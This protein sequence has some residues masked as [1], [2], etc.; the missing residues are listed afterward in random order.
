MSDAVT[1]SV[2]IWAEIVAVAH[3]LTALAASIHCVLT[4]EEPRATIGWVGLIWLSPIIGTVLYYLL[5]INRI[6][7]KAVHLM[8]TEGARELPATP[9][10]SLVGDALPPGTEL[11]RLAKLGDWTSGT[12]LTAGNVVTPLVNGDEAYPAMLAAIGA[13]RTSVALSTYIFDYDDAGRE[14]LEALQ[15]AVRRGVAVRVLVDATGARYSVPSIVKPLKQAGVPVARFLPGLGPRRIAALNLRSHRK[16]LVVD[17]RIGFTGGM[18]IRQENY[19]AR[20]YP[21]PIQDL[22]FRVEGPVVGHLRQAFVEDWV[23]TTREVLSGD[24]WLPPLAPIPDG[25][26]LARGVLDGPDRDFEKI[27]WTIFGAI[28]AARA[29]IRIVTPYFL[30]EA[31]TLKFLA[32]AALAGVRVEIILPERNN[33][34]LVEWAAMAVLPEVLRRN[35]I[36]YL[37]KPPFDHTK[38]MIID[39]AWA[40]IGSA[41]WDARSLRLNFELNVECYGKALAG[42]LGEIFDAK[43]KAAR[44]LRLVEVERRSY[45]VKLRDGVVR[46]LAPYL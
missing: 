40:F 38:M 16:I 23:F 35:C 20:A 41:N 15:A 3:V 36:V 43:L 29:S 9:G 46:L 4:K 33:V 12:R 10:A 44:R 18:N 25:D 11:G 21:R 6:R 2:S 19:L 42:R 7:R 1:T 22:H 27:L 28:S 32:V 34:R 14:F 30:P 24:A 45:P 26:V 31:T 39:D 5:G 13:A 17:G 8:R 37:A